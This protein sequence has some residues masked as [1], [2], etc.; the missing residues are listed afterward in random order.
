VLFL[1]GHNPELMSGAILVDS[2]LRRPSREGAAQQQ[3]LAGI[4]PRSQDQAANGRR[5][6]ASMADA[7]TRFRLVPP[8]P[9]G[10]D[11][12]ADHI[13]RQLLEPVT[14]A[15]GSIVGWRWRYDQQY[16]DKFNYDL[17]D[18]AD[19]GSSLRTP[20]AHIHGESS[21]FRQN[22][23]DP[24]VLPPHAVEFDIP[25][26]HHHAMI[27]QPLALVTAIRAVLAAW[28]NT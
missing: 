10:N 26:A 18:P 28:L 12:I 20:V 5:I 11:F 17:P 2:S 4:T 21:F 13:A 7:L 16:W 22:S 14:G 6:Y 25:R 9:M 3:R 27:D 8:Q 24:K 23:N 19:Y 15:E 1:A